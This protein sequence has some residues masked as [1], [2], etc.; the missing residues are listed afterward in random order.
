VTPPPEVVEAT[1]DIAETTVSRLSACQTLYSSSTGTN[2]GSHNIAR[3]HALLTGWA[4]PISCGTR[5]KVRWQA[6]G[7]C[8]GILGGLQCRNAAP[9]WMQ[10]AET[11]RSYI[12]QVMSNPLDT[13]DGMGRGTSCMMCLRV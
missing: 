12:Q 3:L 13:H 6:C 5:G 8:C 11:S 4:W 10:L 9:E 1:Q 2:R 7:S